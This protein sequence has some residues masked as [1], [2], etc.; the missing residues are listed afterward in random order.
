MESLADRMTRGKTVRTTIKTEIRENLSWGD[1]DDMMGKVVPGAATDVAAF[2]VVPVS[3][4]YVKGDRIQLD[5]DSLVVLSWT[6]EKRS[7]QED[8]K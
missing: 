5:E 3:G 1:V 4:E 7:A 6:L 2:F 8:G